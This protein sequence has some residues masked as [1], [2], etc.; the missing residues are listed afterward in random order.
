M[1]SVKDILN[2]DKVP[3][4]L[5]SVL[6]IVSLMGSYLVVNE[7]LDE[8]PNFFCQNMT[9]KII[10]WCVVYLQ[11][12]SISTASLVCIVIVLLFPRIFFGKLTGSRVKKSE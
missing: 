9:K 1:S 6:I 7:I 3:E 12:K 10:L 5:T 11:T 2:V 8:Y 4:Q